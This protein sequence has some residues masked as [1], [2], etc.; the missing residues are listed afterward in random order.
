MK[1]TSILFLSLLTLA[2]IIGFI[3]VN[4]Q[5]I[6]KINAPYFNCYQQ[7][8]LSKNWKKWQP[9]ISKSFAKDSSLCSINAIPHGFTFVTPDE[10]IL[11]RQQS[12]NVLYITKMLHGNEFNYSYSILAKDFGLTTTIIVDFRSN[13]IRSLIPAFWESDLKKTTINNFKRFME[14]TELYYGFN[15]RKTFINEKKILVKSKTVAAK[16]KYAEAA[17]ML[18]QLHD[19]I[20]IKQ[21]KPAGPV[22]AQYFTK[23]GDSIQMMIGIPVDRE[24]AEHKGLVYMRIPATNALIADF[25]GR[26]GDKQKI[27][28]AV[29]NYM[30]DKFQNPKISPLEI[31]ENKFPANDN[32]TA[33]FRLT[34]P[35]F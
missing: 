6:I 34:Y 27:Y 29:G 35:I 14:N 4:K 21:L 26:Y 25:K 33:N 19:F 24:V 1:R 32:D 22:M 17:T 7:L 20:K 23:Q 18:Q 3:P 5:V 10:H 15:I 8:F 28:A 12:S 30:R 13:I 16:S 11:V 9:D 2:I 31:F